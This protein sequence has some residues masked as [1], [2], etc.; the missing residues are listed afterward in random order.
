[1][2]WDLITKHVIDFHVVTLYHPCII[3]KELFPS[4]FIVYTH[5]SHHYMLLPY[6]LLDHVGIFPTMTDPF[7]WPCD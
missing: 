1:M 7:I 2:K 6:F 5:F 4:P 3:I